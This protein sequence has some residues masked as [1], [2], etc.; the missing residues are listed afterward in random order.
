MRDPYVAHVSPMLSLQ[1]CQE[2]ASAL[3]EKDWYA[4]TDALSAEDVM[5]LRQQAVHL[6]E[7]GLMHPAAIGR[8]TGRQVQPH[9][10]SDLTAWFDE[11]S[12]LQQQFM[13]GLDRLRQT[14][15]EQF[16]LGLIEQEAHFA[17]F[18]AGGFYRRHYD[19]FRGNNA[20]RITVVCYLNPDW[21]AEDGGAIRL[22]KGQEVM[23]DIVPHGGT[24]LVFL[25]EAIPHEVLPA[26]KARYS[27]AAWL[28]I[29][30]A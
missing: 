24:L 18:P 15:N 4:L 17:C 23:T 9:T 20:R 26:L 14:L 3:A 27:I 2:I 10:R 5:Q 6:H 28:R 22:Y 19:S 12:P 29:R 1:Q 21:Q 30:S 16:F 8:G 11:N 13:A 25:S 7:N